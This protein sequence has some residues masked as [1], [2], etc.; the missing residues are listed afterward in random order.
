MRVIVAINVSSSIPKLDNAPPFCKVRSVRLCVNWPSQSIAPGVVFM[1]TL[2]CLGFVVGPGLRFVACVGVALLLQSL[3]LLL[4]LFL[5][6]VL[7]VIFANLLPVVLELLCDVGSPRLL[8]DVD[9]VV[10]N[11]GAERCQRRQNK[12]QE[13]HV[14]YLLHLLPAPSSSLSTCLIRCRRTSD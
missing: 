3:E 10:D 5:F 11:Y 7:R 6:S 9:L 12:N 14:Q 1:D 8:S 13:L 4:N 2:A